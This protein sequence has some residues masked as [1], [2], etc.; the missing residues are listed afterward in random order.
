MSQFVRCQK[1]EKENKNDE[2]HLEIKNDGLSFCE[3]KHLKKEKKE[4]KKQAMKYT[5]NVG[6]HDRIRS[7]V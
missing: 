6:K 1:S 7:H 5:K 2:K 4:T 3:M